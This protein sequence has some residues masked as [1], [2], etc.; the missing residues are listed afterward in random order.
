MALI[1]RILVC[2]S[3]GLWPALL[4]AQVPSSL[5]TGHVTDASSGAPLPGVHVF[6]VGSV[7]GTVTDNEGRFELSPLP[8]GKHEMGF[9]MIGFETKAV[10]VHFTDSTHVVD[11]SLAAQVYEL[12][13]VVVTDRRN[14]RWRRQLKTFQRHFLGES[15]NADQT[16]I[17]NPEVLS[18]NQIRGLFN[19]SAVEPLVLENKALGYRV[20]YKL[21]DFAIVEG[22]SQYRGITRFE[23]LEAETDQ[24]AALWEKNRIQTYQGSF[25]HFLRLLASDNPGSVRD[26]GFLVA[27]VDQL[28]RSQIDRRNQTSAN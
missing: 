6:L 13:Q 8:R 23:E 3:I 11:V 2:L 19:A 10:P 18:F 16:R 1:S 5:V 4:M 24:Q 20:V 12:D 25:K 9:S 22:R 17:I 28:P 15:E 14:R 7:R 21:L 26:Q 27:R